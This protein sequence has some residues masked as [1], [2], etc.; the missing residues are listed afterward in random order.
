MN[1][2]NHFFNIMANFETFTIKKGR[3]YCGFHFSLTTSKE[4]TYDVVFTESCIYRLDDT[5]KQADVNKLFGLSDNYSHSWDSAR[6]GWRF[7]EDKLELLGYSRNNGQHYSQH[8]AFIK[9]YT[10]YRCSVKILPNEYQYTIDNT[11]ITMARTSKYGGLRYLLYPYFGGE[12]VA[13]HEIRLRMK[14]I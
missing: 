9:P 4:L 6:I 10:E 8:L 7:Y 5:S 11:T 3:H 14:H 2:N 13:P 1:I 12:S